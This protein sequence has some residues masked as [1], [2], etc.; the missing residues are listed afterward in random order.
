[1]KWRRSQSSTVLAVNFQV[2]LILN[3]AENP[4]VSTRRSLPPRRG[5]CFSGDS[6]RGHVQVPST[7][8]RCSLQLLDPAHSARM[9][10]SS[11]DSF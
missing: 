4:S 7:G 1:M 5:V 9:K 3:L 10:H 11:L 2:D 6:V 8:V